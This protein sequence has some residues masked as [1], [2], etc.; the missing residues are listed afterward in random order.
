LDGGNDGL[1]QIREVIKKSSILVKKKGKLFLEIGLNQVNE[2]KK[3]L[4]DNKF[5]VNRIVKDLGKKKQM[6]N[7]NKNLD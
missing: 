6:Y 3:L 7:I 1:S 4:I 5:Y 2:T